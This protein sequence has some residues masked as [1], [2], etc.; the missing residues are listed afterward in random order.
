MHKKDGY[1]QGFDYYGLPNPNSL[2]PDGVSMVVYLITDS[3]QDLR[4][5]VFLFFLNANSILICVRLHRSD[6]LIKSDILA[7]RVQV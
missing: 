1:S 7:G 6:Q 2:V 5:Q 4:S 3:N